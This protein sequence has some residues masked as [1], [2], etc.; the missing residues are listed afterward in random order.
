MHF[1]SQWFSFNV[2][3][4]GVLS[5]TNRPWRKTS[6]SV[7]VL[8]QQKSVKEG[9]ETW[10]LH[11]SVFI[12][13]LKESLSASKLQFRATRESAGRLTKLQTVVTTEVIQH[14]CDEPEALTNIITDQKWVAGLRLLEATTQQTAVHLKWTIKAPAASGSA[15]IRENL[16]GRVAWACDRMKC[17]RRITAFPWGLAHCATVPAQL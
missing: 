1:N 7:S 2:V 11:E 15:Q 17:Q 8:W 9:Y 3:P 5:L 12:A 16:P 4:D 13:T 10:S 6:L 14:K